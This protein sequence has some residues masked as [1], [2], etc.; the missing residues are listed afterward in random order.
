M[1][2]LHLDKRILVIGSGAV[3]AYVGGHLSCNGYDVTLVDPWPDHIMEIHE[4]G[5]K[6]EG[7]TTEEAALARPRALHITDLQYLNRESPFHN[8][9]LSVKSYDTDWAA[10]LAALYLAEKGYIVS[11]Q[12]AVNE[13]RIAEVVGEERTVG[14]IASKIVV[15]LIAPGHVVRGVAKGGAKHTVFRVG[16]YNGSTSARTEALA[17]ALSHIDSA[18]VTNNLAGERWTKLVQNAMSNCVSAATGLPVKAY[19]NEER[20][21]RV[22]I[23][24]AGEAVAVGQAHGYQLETINGLPS[25]DW[26]AASATLARGANRSEDL[27][28]VEER[29][30]TGAARMSD[31]A[32]PSMAQDVAKGRRTEINELN[33][34]VVRRGRAKGIETPFNSA[35][36]SAVQQVEQGT[37]DPGLDL[38]P[39]P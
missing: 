30:L 32:R 20:A 14:C 27:A 12:N 4:R 38:L 34:E 33:G 21:R 11:L 10:H 24:L 2:D 15:E 6:L 7:I 23:R 17:N 29:L 26:I 37:V 25:S 39:M 5:L 1:T 19:L 3:G 28:K 35:M 16:E 36:Q 13:H 31:G 9:L 8:V 22:S 18:K